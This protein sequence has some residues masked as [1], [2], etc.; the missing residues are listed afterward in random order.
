[1]KHLSQ[2]DGATKFQPDGEDK[3]IHSSFV[4]EACAARSGDYEP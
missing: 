2:S 4:H 1:M 3:V